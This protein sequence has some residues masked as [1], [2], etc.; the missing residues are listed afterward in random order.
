MSPKEIESS[1]SKSE[2]SVLKRVSKTIASQKL[3]P[4]SASKVSALSAPSKGTVA[5]Y[6]KA[7]QSAEQSVRKALT[8]LEK[9][10]KEAKAEEE[11]KHAHEERLKTLRSKK[12]EALTGELEK[13]RADGLNAAEQDA[14][15][16]GLSEGSD[17]S[18][19]ETEEYK[20]ENHESN[21]PE[22]D[23]TCLPQT[24]DTLEAVGFHESVEPEMIG[25]KPMFFTVSTENVKMAGNVDIPEIFK[26][27]EMK[28]FSVNHP[29]LAKTTKLGKPLASDFGGCSFIPSLLYGAEQVKETILNENLIPFQLVLFLVVFVWEHLL[30][31]DS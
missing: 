24:V 21:E 3:S 12:L 29:C 31:F 8:S 20:D 28:Q 5:D 10:V 19:S 11:R 1:Q 6:D 23:E 26:P 30:G 16:E 22:V 14:A 17:A 15:D 9:L 13:A 18:G 25:L 7:L 4:G 27:E 2:F